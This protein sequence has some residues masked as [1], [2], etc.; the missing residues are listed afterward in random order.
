MG[1]PYGADGDVY[2][3]ATAY[4]G[5]RPPTLEQ[6]NSAARSMGKPSYEE[7]VQAAQQPATGLPTGGGDG[8]FFVDPTLPGRQWEQEQEQY[9]HISELQYQTQL[10]IANINAAADRYVAELN[11]R[12]AQE[13]TDRKITAE[14]GIAARELAQREA[15]FARDIALRQLISDRTYEINQA[16]LALQE[17]EI[18]AGLAAN[19]ADWLT[20][21]AFLG[22]G[23]LPGVGAA[24]DVG[25]TAAAESIR[26]V[27]EGLTTPSGALYN[28]R[29]A[30][31]GVAGAEVPGPQEVSRYQM[32]SMSPS[33]LDMFAGFLRGGIDIGGQ[34]VAIDP[35]DWFQQAQ[36]GFTPTVRESSFMPEYA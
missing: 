21:Q 9:L 1:F 7:H 17:R 19:P 30:G 28:P 3:A 32:Y 12:I 16:Q 13:I 18:K 4:L 23:E 29:L 14:E 36:R 5:G 2:S 22:G 15:E 34:R 24:G 27:A 26:A 35:R 33:E 10:D 6:Y 20:Y 25:E 8:G 11:N 31:V